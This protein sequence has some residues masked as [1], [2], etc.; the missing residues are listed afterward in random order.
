MN[1]EIADAH[2]KKERKKVR[3]QQRLHDQM[4]KTHKTK[5]KQQLEYKV[6]KDARILFESRT[7]YYDP[8]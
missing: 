7:G 3:T 8:V 2:E 6:N 4:I 1:N 5:K